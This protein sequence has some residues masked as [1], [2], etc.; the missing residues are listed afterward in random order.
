[1]IPTNSAEKSTI[2]LKAGEKV[3]VLK[4]T[5]GIYMQLQTGKIIAIRTALKSATGATTTATSPTA[6]DVTK[7]LTP[8]RTPAADTMTNVNRGRGRPPG[9]TN[10]P[11]LYKNQTPMPKP[12]LDAMKAKQNVVAP[13]TKVSGEAGEVVKADSP[14]AETTSPA[15][16]VEVPKAV[17]EEARADTKNPLNDM[18]MLQSMTPTAANITAV[19]REPMAEKPEA[20]GASEPAP[21]AKEKKTNDPV[22]TSYGAKPPLSQYAQQQPPPQQSHGSYHYPQYPQGQDTTTA[23]PMSGYYYNQQQP[24]YGATQP[25]QQQQQQQQLPATHYNEGYPAMNPY[26]AA[27]SSTSILLSSEDEDNNRTDG[28][29]GKQPK[30]RSASTNPYEAALY[31][32]PP[33]SKSLKNYRHKMDEQPPQQHHHHQQQPNK[34]SANE[35]PAPTM[36]ESADY[37]NGGYGMQPQAKRQGTGNKTPHQYPATGHYPQYG[38]KQAAPIYNP[39][40]QQ[41]HSRGYAMPDYS[42]S[43]Q[44]SVEPNKLGYN[45]PSNDA[46]PPYNPKMATGGNQPSAYHT[47]NFSAPPSNAKAPPAQAPYVAPAPHVPIPETNYHQDPY[48]AV[49]TTPRQSSSSST[50][51]TNTNNGSSSGTPYVP[52]TPAAYAPAEQNTT[53]TPSQA[54][55]PPPTGYGQQQ[56]PGYEQPAAKHTNNYSI[57]A[58]TNP[59]DTSSATAASVP[60]ATPTYPTMDGGFG[61]QYPRHDMSSMQQYPQQQQQHHHNLHPHHHQQQQQQQQPNQLPPSQSHSYTSKLSNNYFYY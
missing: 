26:P 39:H 7:I 2:V 10:A 9:S 28:K 31:S 18:S 15:E 54:S 5:K 3:M 47:N 60:A 35:A 48:G 46:H 17:A 57:P 32:P 33:S 1:V 16:K 56:Y 13:S 25:S 27:K 11:S 30:S 34:G 24:G 51:N 40:Q 58:P 59:L 8:V 19:A 43:K 12:V 20:N 55:Q 36:A 6:G 45:A 14:V 38:E 22:P 37:S 4:S 29:G 61:M 44:Q 49:Y 23:P 53:K 52:S 50:S 42:K 41:P 21:V